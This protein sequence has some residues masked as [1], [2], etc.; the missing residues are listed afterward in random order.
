MR[1][2]SLMLLGVGVLSIAVFCSAQ[3]K[4]PTAQSEEKEQVQA[5][6]KQLESGDAKAR[7]RAAMSF[8]SNGI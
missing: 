2:P 6:V 1:L 3:E 5:L 4:D 7:Y 8:A